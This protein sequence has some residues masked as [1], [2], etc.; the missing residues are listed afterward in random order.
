MLPHSLRRL[1]LGIVAA[2]AVVAL[3]AAAPASAKSKTYAV[4][5]AQIPVDVNAGTYKMTGGLIGDWATT[6]FTELAKSPIY[7]GKG[8]EKFSGCLDRHHDG[9]CKGDPSGTLKFDFRYWASFTAAGDLVW[10]SCWHPITGGTGDFAGAVGVLTMVD[11]PTGAGGQ[12]ATTA[13]V[14]NVT[15]K[16]DKSR[17]KAHA[18]AAAL[19]CGG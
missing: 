13:Y 15:L 4:S 10:G 3:V 11:T 17:S 8:T 7:K 1:G 19:T 5:G 9:S 2:A 6:S 18:R 16:G 14:G 12:D